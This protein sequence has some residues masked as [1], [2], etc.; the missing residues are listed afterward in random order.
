MPRCVITGCNNN[1]NHSFP[2][3]LELRKL[4]EKATKITNFAATKNLRICSQHFK[5]TDFQGLCD[6]TGL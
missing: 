5:E 4:W 3:D 6:A 1:G 2:K